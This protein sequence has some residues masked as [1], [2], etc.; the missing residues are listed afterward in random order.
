MLSD[1]ENVSCDLAGE[2]IIL[3]MRSGTYYGLNAVGAT[4][5]NLLSSQR[6]IGEL[7][8]AVIDEYEVEREQCEDD[9]I[10]LVR[11]LAERGLVRLN[12]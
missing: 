11:Q 2:A 9:L 1:P 6:S 12:P 7:C 5:W 8:A 3:N 10:R 4:V